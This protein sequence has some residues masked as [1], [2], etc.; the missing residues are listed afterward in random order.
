M[1]INP[2]P[3][4]NGSL[5]VLNAQQAD[6]IARGMFNYLA[7]VLCALAYARQAVLAACG[8]ACRFSAIAGMRARGAMVNELA[9][10]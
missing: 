4:K 3:R 1:Q 6:L 2:A 9:K 7:R 8:G 5:R 10:G